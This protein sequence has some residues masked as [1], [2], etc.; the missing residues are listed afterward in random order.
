M[1][2]SARIF[3]IL[4]A[5]GLVYYG[6]HDSPN[7]AAPALATQGGSPGQAVH[8]TPG[9]ASRESAARALQTSPVAPAAGQA[10]VSSAAS[11]TYQSIKNAAPPPNITWSSTASPLNSLSPEE[12]KWFPGA[13]VV[14]A[15]VVPGPGAD[16][17]TQVR[18]LATSAGA[19]VPA[20]RTEEIVNTATS[21]VVLREEMAAD[22]LLVTLA[23]GV[24]PES[25]VSAFP[26]QLASFTRVTR[27]VPLYNFY[28]PSP[29][30]TS[31]PDAIE[32]I[33]SLPDS[34]IITADPN[35]IRKACQ[36]V[37]PTKFPDDPFFLGFI[38]EKSV[39]CGPL[40]GLY[41]YNG[42]TS[43]RGPDIHAPEGW[44][45]RSETIPGFIVAVID[46][47]IRYTHD[48][49]KDN[50]WVNPKVDVGIDGV[51]G[52]NAITGALNPGD[53]MDDNG[54]G[55]HCAGTIGAVG[56]NGIGVTGVAWRNVKLM[57]LKFLDAAGDG[58]DADAIK[59]IDYAIAKGAKVLSNSWGGTGANDALKAAIARAKAAGIIFVAAAGNK[60]T[61]NDLTPHYPSSYSL[62]L[63]NVVAVAATDQNDALATF[64]NYGATSVNLAAPGVDIWSTY[65][66]TTA[67]TINSN[68]VY[69]SLEGTSMA[70]PYVSGVL[71]LLLSQYPM[72]AAREQ[73]LSR[74][75]DKTDKLASLAGKCTTGGRLNLYNSLIDTTPR[76]TPTPRPV[77]VPRTTPPRS[78][79]PRLAP[80]PVP[81]PTPIATPVP[82]T[83]TP[84]PTT[85]PSPTP[86]PSPTAP[87]VAT[88]IPLPTPGP[89][90]TPT[91]TPGGA[92][93]A[94]P[95]R[96]VV[97]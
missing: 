81:T 29:S 50:M 47:G 51:H 71:A 48:D 3:A 95:I 37:I 26:E 12:A 89:V 82:T 52:I 16:Q 41:N 18:I 83:P 33:S 84:A 74:L 32:A 66:G 30:L 42:T 64:S 4:V 44:Y 11:R 87:P 8:S 91:P 90:A 21:Q 13:K 96:R 27:S 20:V 28:T 45:I 70:T 76:P 80:V 75:L 6:V 55:T 10:T 53:P 36:T 88:P 78:T 92:P 40:W 73:I 85:T 49:L 68:S 72:E 35:F 17:Q 31:L 25:L 14:A 54:H 23:D 58:S 39:L 67:A 60:K 7:P 2:F 62:V 46:T 56:N 77:P 15:V 69:A 43:A 63:S 38:N 61:D 65:I 34:S 19:C 79:S 1:K 57:A 97:R 22:Q 94:T 93:R 86:T 59:C 24:T 9:G 5:G